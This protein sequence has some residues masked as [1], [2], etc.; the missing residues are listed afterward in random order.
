[1]SAT[2]KFDKSRASGLYLPLKVLRLVSDICATRVAYLHSSHPTIWRCSS[3]ETPSSQIFLYACAVVTLAHRAKRGQVV[4]GNIH[5]E[6]DEDTGQFPP[7]AG[8]CTSHSHSDWEHGFRNDHYNIS[9]KGEAR[10]KEPIR[11]TKTCM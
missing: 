2:S 8:D 4:R 3:Y 11:K 9:V 10:R 1:M 6:L 7:S 5:R